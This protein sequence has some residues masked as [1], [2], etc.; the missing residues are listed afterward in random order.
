M[1][2]P[3]IMHHNT[4]SPQQHSFPCFFPSEAAE[5]VEVVD[6]VAVHVVPEEVDEPQKPVKLGN[7]PGLGEN[8]IYLKIYL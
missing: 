3:I 7:W 6:A 8:I 1:E 4:T 5:H 2:P